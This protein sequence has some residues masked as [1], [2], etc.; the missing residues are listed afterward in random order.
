[1]NIQSAFC[2]H[3]PPPFCD[4]RP[5]SVCSIPDLGKQGL[6]LVFQALLYAKGHTAT[7]PD[8]WP[9]SQ[10]WPLTSPACSA[11][12]LLISVNSNSIHP[13]AQI[14]RVGVVF[15]SSIAFT[16]HQYPI[17]PPILSL[18]L[19]RASCTPPHLTSPTKATLLQPQIF[20][21]WNT[22]KESSLSCFSYPYPFYSLFSL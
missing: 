14:K 13:V 4:L 10:A 11:P 6:L 8:V 17:Q 9:L 7:N 5:E 16:L 15:D 19:Q 18:C 3:H 22:A 12:L 2:W 1:M 20:L 21:V